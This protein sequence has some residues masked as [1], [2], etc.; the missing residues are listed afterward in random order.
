MNHEEVRIAQQEVE[1]STAEFNIALDRVVDRIEV[2]G[3]RVLEM[4]D[5]AEY[6]VKNPGP[7]FRKAIAPVLDEADEAIGEFMNKTGD[8]LDR[9]ITTLSEKAD[10]ALI[11]MEARPVGAWL[12]VFFVGCLAGALFSRRISRTQVLRPV[13][14]GETGFL[15]AA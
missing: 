8:R 9:M 1:R 5:E 12:T 6:V 14:P 2:G 3:E 13:E 7:A 11:E 4:K 10:E 15:R